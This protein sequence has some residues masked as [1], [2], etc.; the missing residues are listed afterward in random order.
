MEPE[1]ISENADFKQKLPKRDKESHFIL[2]NGITHQKDIRI[3][4]IHI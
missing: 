2:I 4:N 1:S 3:I